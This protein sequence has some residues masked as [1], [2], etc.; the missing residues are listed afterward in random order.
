MESIW[1]HPLCPKYLDIHWVQM[2]VQSEGHLLGILLVVRICLSCFIRVRPLNGS[3]AE[4][5]SPAF[6]F[7]AMFFLY[8]LH[9]GLHRCI[10]T[11]FKTAKSALLQGAGLAG[12]E[13][14][15]YKQG[16]TPTWDSFW[17]AKDLDAV[18][19]DNAQ[20]DNQAHTEA[21]KTGVSLE[22]TKTAS[23]ACSCL[24]NKH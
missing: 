11:I 15:L 4:C 24:E 19:W 3:Q 9:S 23:T 6:L 22:T 10:S 1:E 21:W 2:V 20:S 5:Q 16:S 8:V 13:P 17:Q 14:C 12:P 7:K 18:P